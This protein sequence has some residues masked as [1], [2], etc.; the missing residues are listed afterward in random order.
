MV[1][2]ILHDNIVATAARC[3]GKRTVLGGGSPLRDIFHLL[4]THVGV[5]DL[6]VVS[7]EDARL[8]SSV[9]ALAVYRAWKRQ[10]A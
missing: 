3:K 4:L 6:T 1:G 7:D 2:A 9:G 10:Q 5:E 8:A